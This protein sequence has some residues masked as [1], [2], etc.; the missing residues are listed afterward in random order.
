MGK[1]GLFNL[2][3][4]ISRT[5]KLGGSKLMF[6]PYEIETSC[7]AGTNPGYPLRE[8]LQD[9]IDFRLYIVYMYQ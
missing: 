7:T 5:E 6:M 2:Y 9:F 4:Y 1:I 3:M 8:C